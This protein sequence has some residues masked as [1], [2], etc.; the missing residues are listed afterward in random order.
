MTKYDN[1]NYEEQFEIQ[2]KSVTT[3]NGM[4]LKAKELKRVT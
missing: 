2:K 3:T 1:V 4:K